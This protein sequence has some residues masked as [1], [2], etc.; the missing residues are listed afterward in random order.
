MAT[1]ETLLS[2][3]RRGPK[4]TGIGQMIGVRLQPDD[5]KKLDEWIAANDKSMSRPEAIRRL[6]DI[7]VNVV[8]LPRADLSEISA[9]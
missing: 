9:P 2:G 5:L 3:K 4:P 6:I 8:M 7:G 1:Q